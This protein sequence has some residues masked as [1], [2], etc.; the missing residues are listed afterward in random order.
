MQFVQFLLAVVPGVAALAMLF[1]AVS[2]WNG[3]ALPGRRAF[4]ALAAAAG[5]WCFAAALEYLSSSMAPRV[6]FAKFVYLGAATVP[7][8]WFVF[9][10]QYVGRDRW[11][12]RR[13]IELLLAVPVATILLA[14][15]NEWHGLIWQEVAFVTDPIP[16][17]AIE[18]GAWFTTVHQPYS[19]GLF[20]L[21]FV[22]LSANFF[23]DLALYRRQITGLLASATLIFMVN[24]AYTVAD[25][26]IYGVDPTPVLASVFLLAI[27]RS[28]FADLLKMS[29]ISY[30]EVFLNTD[31]A[32]LLV[33][34]DGLIVE[35]NPAADR[36]DW[37]RTGEQR[38]IFEALPWLE[39]DAL[40]DRESTALQDVSADNG[41]R[42]V[43]AKYCPLR[44]QDGV[45]QGGAF[46]LRD[47]TGRERE[48]EMLA[49]LAR[50]DSL[51]AALNRRAFVAEVEARLQQ[52]PP[53]RPLA[54]LFVD[55]NRFKAVNDEHGHAAG[56]D[57]LKET[58]ARIQAA[59][60]PGDLVGRLGGDEFAVLVDRAE[61]IEA[62][63]MGRRVRESFA[64]PF[65][66]D[67]R[68]FTVSASVGHA[69]WPEDGLTADELLACA[70]RK[71]YQH[72]R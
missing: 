63:R 52:R 20:L 12:N 50:Q 30:R 37:L 14:L 27:A 71:M 47:V 54:L 33:S 51:T 35:T 28:L 23:S 62:N 25:V 49:Q 5:I 42:V 4:G 55:L 31:D 32:V 10:M 15:T 3:R 22:A 45:L 44:D 65:V 61:H 2:A 53:E 70:D 66:H 11:L 57:V 58:V 21:G 6:L 9:A 7:V 60:R 67:G 17:L 40:P 18:H 16:D 26:S 38:T 1:L 59:L 36:L 34:A 43:E 39:G 41:Q 56:D 72:K 69:T 48:R 13:V 19:Y 8:A 24:I 68:E 46:L 64:S 29:P